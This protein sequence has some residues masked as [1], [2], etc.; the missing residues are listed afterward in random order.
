MTSFVDLSCFHIRPLIH[1]HFIQL[2][3]PVEHHLVVEGVEVWSVVR[4]VE[5]LLLDDHA[6]QAGSLL[7]KSLQLLGPL[8][9][10]PTGT[11][12][13][14]KSHLV[15][16]FLRVDW[17]E[18][19]GVRHFLLFGQAANQHMPIRLRRCH[20]SHLNIAVHKMHVFIAACRRWI[21]HL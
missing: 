21:L 17:K 14:P 1:D 5:W 3:N 6:L 11:R 16:N 8:R 7:L 13:Q 12:H 15:P 10:R 9:L 4:W 18:V 19:H 2:F 20:L